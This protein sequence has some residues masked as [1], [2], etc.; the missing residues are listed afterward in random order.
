MIYLST[1]N[2]SIVDS[3]ERGKIRQNDQ[4]KWLSKKMWFF[5]AILVVVIIIMIMIMII[6]IIIIMIIIII[7]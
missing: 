7:Y 3:S 4:I 2:L 1:L 6:I 5:S